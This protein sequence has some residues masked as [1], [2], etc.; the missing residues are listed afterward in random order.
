VQPQ[1]DLVNLCPASFLS[2]VDWVLIRLLPDKKSWWILCSA[3]DSQVGNV[4]Q[5]RFLL[6]NFCYT[7]EVLADIVKINCDGQVTTVVLAL[8][9]NINTVYTVYS[10]QSFGYIFV[11]IEGW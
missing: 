8:I 2:S 11:T 6:L 7:K 9:N 10:S 1:F 3:P 4:L 5:K